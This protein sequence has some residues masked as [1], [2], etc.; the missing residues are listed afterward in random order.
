VSAIEW[1][2]PG[3]LRLPPSRSSVDLLKLVEQYRRFGPRISGMPPIEVT[4]CGG[5]LLVISDG[6]TR[7]TR[8][9]RFGAVGALVPV[10]VTEERLGVDASK[11]PQIRDA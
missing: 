5:G 3:D 1:V 7:A 8:A 6:V 4:R 9:H 11:L 2:V 10:T